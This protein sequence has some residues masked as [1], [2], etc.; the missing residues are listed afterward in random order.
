MQ[1]LNM[2]FFHLNYLGLAEIFLISTALFLL[3]IVTYFVAKK[4]LLKII[5]KAICH[6]KPK[7][8]KIIERQ[9]TFKQ[10]VYMVPTLFLYFWVQY[11]PHAAVYITRLLNL[12]II[13]N[14]V[15]L[16]S[17]ILKTISDIY[18]LYPVAKE[19]PIKNYMQL[20]NIFSYIIGAVVAICVVMDISPWGFLSGVTALTAVLLL[21]FRET[22]LS[23]IAGVQI[24]ANRLIQTGDWIE[25]P[26]F[27]ANGAV[28]EVA[29]HVVK[30]QN[31]DKTIVSIPTYK[32]I[33][34]GFKNWRGMY[35]SGGR[36]IKRSMPIDQ[37]SIRSISRQE[38]QSILTTP[39]IQ[40][41]L[42]NLEWSKEDRPGLQT[43]LGAFRNYIEAYLRQR[44]DT[45]QNYTFIV[46]LLEPTATGIPLE[47]YLFT[48][49]TT[50][51]IHE[52]IQSE[53][54][55]HLLATIS[56]FNLR[57]FQ[58]PSGYDYILSMTT[59]PSNYSAPQKTSKSQIA[60]YT[61]A[62]SKL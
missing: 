11:F 7:W 51:A 20:L 1:N 36:R 16:V 32:L 14:I 41:S 5:N 18:K 45:N 27:G 17:N 42:Q 48:N 46:R 4:Y 61:Q 40:N 3:T 62:E 57:V 24:I 13:I 9:Q 47:L 30:V 2:K 21:V 19:N 60:K 44:T 28:L 58:E 25:V 34:A 29:L 15:L 35:D 50:W 12:Y 31:W 23:F 39:Q 52:R 55:E 37:T 26:Q 22:I 43:N 56:L 59:Q 8:K 49:Q 54:F 10:L 53:I 33:E 6:R 38:L